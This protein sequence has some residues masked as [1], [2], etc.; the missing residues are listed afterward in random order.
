MELISPMTPI[1]LIITLVLLFSFQGDL[2][3]D[4]PL[5][6]ALIAV[7]LIIQTVVMYATSPSASWMHVQFQY[8]SV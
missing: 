4:Q 8:P 1:G 7:P 2:L 6:I 3:L 5:H